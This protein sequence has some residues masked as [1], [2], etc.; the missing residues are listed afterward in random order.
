[1]KEVFKN[2]IK[3]LLGNW[4]FILILAGGFTWYGKL[5]VSNQSV[6]DSIGVVMSDTRQL[7]ID[8][9]EVKTFM[10]EKGQ[11]IKVLKSEN[12][13]LK[14]SHIRTLEGKLKDKDE[15]LRYERERSLSL[16]EILKKND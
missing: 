16:E 8:M 15:A 11:D 3:W 9:G 6:V 12:Q 5:Q 14:D 10:Q 7:K 4:P 2:S 13:A 1:M